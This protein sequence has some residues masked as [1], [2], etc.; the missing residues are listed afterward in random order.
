MKRRPR[1]ALVALAL[2]CGAPA[3]SVEFRNASAPETVSN[4]CSVDADCGTNATCTGGLCFSKSGVIDEV[5]LEVVPDA[6]SSAGGLS[7]LSMQTGVMQGDRAR[8]VALPGQ[9]T[10]I[11]QVLANGTDLQAAGCK[12]FVATGAQTIQARIEFSRVGAIGGVPILG[13]NSVPVTIDTTMNAGGWNAMASLLPGTYDIYIQP[14]VA[15]PN[16]E[17]APRILRGV[18]IPQ[19][20]PS[21]PPATLA[22][23]TPATLYGKV[24]RTSK[25]GDT[26]SLEGWTVDVIEPQE[27]RVISTVAKLGSTLSS[28][29][30]NFVVRY[31]RLAT[32]PTSTST[33]GS[34]PAAGPLIRISPPSGMTDSAPVVYWDLA[35]ADL[36]GDGHCSLDMSGVPSSSTL[37]DV[38]GQILGNGDAVQGKP[39]PANLQFYSVSL[40][41][42]DGLTA[43][44]NRLVATDETG[45]YATQLFPGQYRVVVIPAASPGANIVAPPSMV[46]GSPQPMGAAAL[47]WAIQEEQWTITA[48][49]LTLDA[50]LR[51]K[52]T[53]AGSV[54]AGASTEPDAPGAA[55][56]AIPTILPS[57]VGA[58]KGAL[59]QVPILPQNASISVGPDSTFSLPLDPGDF[60]I[61]V[62]TPDSSN[63]AWWVW[64]SAHIA[65]PDA[66]DSTTTI[67]PHI[68]FPVPLEGVITVPDATGAAMPLRS[69]AVRA[70]AKVPSGTGVTKVGDTR[71]DDMG[72]YRLRLPPSFGGP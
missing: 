13:L 30:T 8:T 65:L 29:M 31:E 60:D 17:I 32:P 40:D 4:S 47:P 68:P 1:S 64:P 35:A 14:L 58:L 26:T 53:V 5:L 3:C 62:R 45:H 7:F 49:A 55:I 57:Q 36:A 20:D 56:N 12:D 6:N 59:A 27:G 23:P 51:Q 66:N 34:T 38:S 21:V 70:Y 10:F 61:S 19:V 71:T 9:T 11:T 41:G 48:G 2:A 16:C 15:D 46:Q 33:Q 39:V 52:R 50:T 43:A 24:Q 22:L 63:F 54:F 37:V 67:E 28:M 69:A 25:P 18:D 44:F 72:R 42:A